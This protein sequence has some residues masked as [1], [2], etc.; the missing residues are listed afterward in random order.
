MQINQDELARLFAQGA[1]VREMA[2]HFNWSKRAVQYAMS[3]LRKSVTLSIATNEQVASYS[4]T[5]VGDLVDHVRAAVQTARS[6]A[7]IS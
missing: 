7:A 4:V 3:R 6:L 2:E 5:S 1:T